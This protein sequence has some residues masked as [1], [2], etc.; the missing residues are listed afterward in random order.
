MHRLDN[1]RACCEAGAR[2]PP[3]RAHGWN[4]AV[5]G[6]KSSGTP[7][8]FASIGMR[9]ALG[10]ATGPT[11]TESVPAVL[12]P[13]SG[14]HPRLAAGRGP[15]ARCWSRWSPPPPQDGFFISGLPGV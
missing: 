10:A 1:R 4:H 15:S 6:G 9:P 14:S 11:L 12:L 7:R 2:R 3:L 13:A 8:W 5:R